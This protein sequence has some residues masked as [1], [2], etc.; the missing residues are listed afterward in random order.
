MLI[1]YGVKT[2]FYIAFKRILKLN[3]KILNFNF[4][5]N[6]ERAMKIGASVVK[7]E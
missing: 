2:I 3:F 7:V 4:N 1:F 6:L 5:F